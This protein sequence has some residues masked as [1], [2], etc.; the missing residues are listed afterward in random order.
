MINQAI[1]SVDI[2]ILLITLISVVVGVMRGFIREALSVVS[3]VLAIWLAITYCKE[4]GQ[5]LSGYVSIST[6]ALE[7]ALGFATT[8]I[9]SLLVF[10]LL[11]YL[12]H[13]LI[14]QDAIKG[15]DRML[16]ALFGVLRA[17]IIVAAMMVIGRSID[18][19]TRDWWQNS[20]L[21]AQ[22]KPSA[23]ILQSLLPSDFQ[24]A[25]QQQV[26]DALNHAE[27]IEAIYRQG[28]N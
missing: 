9:G 11:T 8:F 12:I 5:Y 14:V 24:P 6:P 19:Q 7:V 25:S 2:I 15:T 18:M 3:W 28:V 23:D 17:V 21:L 13:K 4:A 27:D 26:S 1:N 20:V 22:L 10:A 16:G